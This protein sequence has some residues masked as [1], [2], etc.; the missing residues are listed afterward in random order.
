MKSLESLWH[1]SPP[2]QKAWVIV[3]MSTA[4]DRAKRCAFPVKQERTLTISASSVPTL[5]I[6]CTHNKYVDLCNVYRLVRK[7]HAPDGNVL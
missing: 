2:R 1:L 5:Q 7:F 4:S 3:V 6:L